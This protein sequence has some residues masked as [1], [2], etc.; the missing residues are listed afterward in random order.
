M[1]SFRHPEV[2]LIEVAFDV[3]DLPGEPGL[4]IVTYSVPPGTDSADKFALLESWAATV[5]TE[6][7][8]RAAATGGQAASGSTSPHR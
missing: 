5:D 1:R 3:F 6:R 7:R 4:H 8:N 2:G